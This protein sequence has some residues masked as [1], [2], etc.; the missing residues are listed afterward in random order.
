MTQSWC[1]LS[2]WFRGLPVNK[3][4]W[5]VSVQAVVMQWNEYLAFCEASNLR[6]FLLGSDGRV[7]TSKLAEATRSSLKLCLP[8]NLL[9]FFFLIFYFD[10]CHKNI[11][12]N[13]FFVWCISL[14]PALQYCFQTQWKMMTNQQSW[15]YLAG[16]LCLYLQCWKNI[17]GS[18][19]KSTLIFSS[20]EMGAGCSLWIS[21]NPCWS[22]KAKPK[23]FD[24]AGKSF[25]FIHEFYC[26]QDM[27]KIL[28]LHVCTG[29]YSCFCSFKWRKGFCSTPC[30]VSVRGNCPYF[31]CCFYIAMGTD[32]KYCI[33]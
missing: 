1:F 30:T 14:L 25:L 21:P 15:G 18:S 17:W 27:G 5:T 24:L 31:H 10:V 9:V 3:L 13:F 16:C 22:D 29:K 7:E 4:F 11:L 20:G 6:Y 33:H 26:G 28:A 12:G 19:S 8:V 2:T 23:F 32:L